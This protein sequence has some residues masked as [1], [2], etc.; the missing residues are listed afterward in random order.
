MTT[1]LDPTIDTIVD[2]RTA[3]DLVVDL[4]MIIGPI[5]VFASTVAWVADQEGA[6]AVLQIWG[7]IGLGM[8]L[9]GLAHRLRLTVPLGAA[10][11]LVLGLAGTSVGTAYGLEIAMVDYFGVERLNEQEVLTA[12]LGLQLPGLMFPLSLLVTAVLGRRH[13]M[14]GAPAAVLLGVAAAAFPASR[15]PAE[16]GIALVADGLLLAA[17]APVGL[18]SLRAARGA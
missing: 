8:V 5:L 4:A 10:A 9:A 16:A 3:L 2:R 18:A 6:R 17:L 13:G 7:M 12:H 1:Q 11:I 15:I 14:F